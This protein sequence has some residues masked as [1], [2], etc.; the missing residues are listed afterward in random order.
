MKP[1]RLRLKKGA[2]PSVFG[3]HKESSPLVTVKVEIKEEEP[4]KL[5]DV[6]LPMTSVTIKEEI[7]E[8]EEEDEAEV[9]PN[10]PLRL[11][12]VTIKQE[13]K[14]EE[15]EILPDDHLRVSEKSLNNKLSEVTDFRI[16]REK[17]NLI[18]KPSSL[19]TVRNTSETIVWICWS[20]N[21]MKAFRK[22][23]L[24]PD[25]SVKV[26]KENYFQVHSVFY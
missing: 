8:E 6:P 12:S 10:V 13:I 25:L 20:M 26:Q 17:S 5:S 11:P 14:Q 1:I 15:S 23:I 24:H 19:W 9:V 2:V 18:P 7:K 22:V 4:E 3:F 21:Y 16:I